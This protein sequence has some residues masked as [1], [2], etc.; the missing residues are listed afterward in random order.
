MGKMIH[1]YNSS[2]MSSE[3]KYTQTSL[4]KE[5]K[6]ERGPREDEGKKKEV[7]KRERKEVQ[8]WPLFFFPSHSL[9]KKKKIRRKS[10]WG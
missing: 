6:E 7:K 5:T 10:R 8:A 4:E 1:V 9:A 3:K 2:R